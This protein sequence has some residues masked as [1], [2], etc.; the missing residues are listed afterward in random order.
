MHVTANSL[1]ERFYH[2]VWNR[3]DEAVAREILHRNFAFAPRSVRNGGGRTN[4]SST[5]DR[6]MPPWPTIPAASKILSRQEI[7]RPRG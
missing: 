7:V 3:A 1:V 4:S 5:R 2:D 6:S